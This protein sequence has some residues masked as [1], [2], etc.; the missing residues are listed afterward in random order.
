MNS[1]PVWIRFALCNAVWAVADWW[2]ATARPILTGEM[3][4]LCVRVKL[5]ALLVKHIVAFG[6]QD[7]DKEMTKGLSSG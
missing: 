5:I 6:E 1:S 2:P 7:T 4:G 3:K